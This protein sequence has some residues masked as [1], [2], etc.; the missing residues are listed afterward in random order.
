VRGH[1]AAVVIRRLPVAR[2]AMCRALVARHVAAILVWCMAGALAVCPSRVAAQTVD[3]IRIEDDNGQLDFWLPPPRRPDTELTNAAQLRIVADGALLWRRLTHTPACGLAPIA[4]RC[5]TTE[6]QIGQEMFT[7]AGATESAAPRPG[8]RPYAGWL[9]LSA[10]AQAA[11]PTQ[12]DAVTIETGV[13]GQ[14]SLAETI[15]TAW[16][17]LIGYPRALG[18]SHQIPFQFGVLVAAERAQEVVHASLGGVPVLMLIPRAGISLGNV[19]TGAHAG[20]EARIGYGVT[21]PWSSAIRGRGRKVELYGIA[22]IR[23]DLVAYDLFLDGHTATHVAKEP[24]VFQY[25]FGAGLRFGALE[26]EYRGLTQGREYLTGPPL[27]PVGTLGVGIRP[28]W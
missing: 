20:A 11:T 5:A 23:E 12:S 22:A 16:H 28:G 13:T 4:D 24:A 6:L 9:Y 17:T 8:T 21:S 7:P 19:L 2:W 26:V 27:H 25:E 1:G 15:Q 3:E 14:P 10:A 18:W